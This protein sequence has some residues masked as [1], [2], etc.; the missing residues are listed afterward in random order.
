MGYHL[1]TSLGR[2]P[3]KSYA[4]PKTH[5]PASQVQE[6]GLRFY[7]PGLGRWVNRDPIGERGGNNLYVAC[8]NCP[9]L[10][11]DPLGQFTLSSTVY[12]R[13]PGNCGK[14]AVERFF[15]L[16]KKESEVF[17]AKGWVVQEISVM[18]VVWNRS[19][20]RPPIVKPID[21]VE[22]FETGW[23]TV[24][25]D[26]T[27]AIEREMPCTVGNGLFTGV[28][29]YQN[30]DVV[31]LPPWEVSGPGEHPAGMLPHINTVPKDF[32]A[33]DSATHT[34]KVMVEWNCILG[35]SSTAVTV[36]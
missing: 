4:T 30:A 21:Y 23:G 5:T 25:Y 2:P 28:A 33:P 11:G 26:D 13:S 36:L 27:F 14:F 31:R 10:W 34:F 24:A 9:I 32:P 6:R 22:A 20:S 3:A 29:R 15:N 19:L 8:I 1:T 17:A 7:S 16:A 35:T 18:L 12:R